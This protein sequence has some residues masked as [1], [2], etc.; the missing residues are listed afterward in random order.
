MIREAKYTANRR[1][2]QYEYLIATVDQDTPME[3]LNAFGWLGWELVSVT[4]TPQG[5]RA[6][7]KRP[8]R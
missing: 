1:S 3:Q 2:L 7:L 4:P 8:R 5:E 6:Y